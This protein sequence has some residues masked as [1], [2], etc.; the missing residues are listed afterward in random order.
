MPPLPM[1][2]H[3][4]RHERAARHMGR[5]VAMIY[6]VYYAERRHAERHCFAA[7]TTLHTLPFVY[8]LVCQN[9]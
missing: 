6:I 7:I 4:A 2:C 1:I 8:W 5:R 9:E 3:E